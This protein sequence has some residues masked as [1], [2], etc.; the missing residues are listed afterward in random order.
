MPRV[1]RWTPTVEAVQ[2]IRSVQRENIVG[3]HRVDRTSYDL[4]RREAAKWAL[5]SRQGVNEWRLSIQPKP[6]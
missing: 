1:D 4:T 3:T 2:P 6:A 5:F